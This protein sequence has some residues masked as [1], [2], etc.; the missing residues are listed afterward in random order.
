MQNSG[1]WT[2]WLPGVENSRLFA[3]HR[4]SARCAPCS[5]RKYCPL[6]EVA[7]GRG[8]EGPPW[9]SSHANRCS[10]GLKDDHLPA[11]QQGNVIKDMAQ[12]EQRARMHIGNVLGLRFWH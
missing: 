7:G 2:P 6:V 11:R 9:A 3:Q 4:H 5:P 10:N 12:A 1:P 8:M